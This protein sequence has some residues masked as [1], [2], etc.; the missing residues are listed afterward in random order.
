MKFNL[1]ECIGFITNTTMKFV[2]EDFNRRLEAKGS[3]RIQWIALYF[4]N[5]ENKPISQKELASLMNIKDSSVARLVDRMER[6]GLIKRVENPK[7]KRVK[8]LELTNNGRNQ[9]EALLP[10]GK[11]FSDLLLE[12]ITNEELLTFYKVLDKMSIN[13]KK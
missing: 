8:F 2:S 4:L 7:D 12:G 9:I 5:E 3:T 6:D 11:Y 13:I 1:S 10:E